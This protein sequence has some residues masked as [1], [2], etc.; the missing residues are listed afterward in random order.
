MEPAP[1]IRDR[2][3][4]ERLGSVDRTLRVAGALLL[5]LIWLGALP[6]ASDEYDRARRIHDR[7]SGVPPSDQVLELMAQQI[8]DGNPEGAGELA[9]QHRAFFNSTLK[10]YV[11]P[12]TN[13]E[14]TVFA[15]LNDY[16]ATVIGIIR[17]RRSFKEVLTGDVIYVG[18][19]QTPAYSR[20]DN[21]H[22]EALEE[23]GDDLS[24][25][26]VLEP[27]FQDQL[28][29]S[30]MRSEAAGVMT[31]RAAGKAF[32]R[33]GTNRR[34]IRFLAINYLCRDMEALTDN[35]RPPDRIRQDVSRSPGGDSEI[36]LNTCAG[37]H[38]GMDPLAGAF[39]FFEWEPVEDE[40]ELGR[41]VHTRGV[42]QTKYLI[43]GNTFPFGHETVDDRWDNYWRT[44][45]NSVLGWRSAETGGFGP[46]SLGHQ[47]ADS[48]TFSRC[49]VEKVF[50]QVCFKPPSDLTDRQEVEA[51][52]LDFEANDH[53]L[54]DVFADVAAYCTEG[55]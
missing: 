48:E 39:A 26:S 29:N 1:I 3:P 44:G 31:T 36:F 49:Q 13:E 20:D 10:T 8:R 50:E 22:Y 51:I 52:R 16:S 34:M 6:A 11:T 24:L 17:D 42:V 19:N 4:A 23:S 35:T 15:P 40:P 28:N 47:I 21:F 18:A 30:I 45:T 25:M 33:A 7:L 55:L 2:G 27:R 41:V 9:M 46:N 38:T 32:F 53:D 54:M 37:C 12:W 43:N 5:S 14:Q